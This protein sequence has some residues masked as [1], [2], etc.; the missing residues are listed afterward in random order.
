MGE[1]DRPPIP[2]RAG[3]RA[4]GGEGGLMRRLSNCETDPALRPSALT[5]IGSS[6][7]G[8]PLPRAG[9]VAVKAGYALMLLGIP[10][11]LAASVLQV[12]RNG[13]QRSLL[14]KSGPW[15]ATLVRV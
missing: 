3:R 5:T 8:P 9:E 14:P 13:L 12:A 15:A 10:A 1:G 11:T 6:A 7:D 2:A 4:G